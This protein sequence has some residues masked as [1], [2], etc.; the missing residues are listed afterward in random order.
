MKKFL[1][2]LIIIFTICS[3]SLIPERS[4]YEQMEDDRFGSMF[5]P[6]RDFRVVSGDFGHVHREQEEMLSRTPASAHQRQ[7]MQFQDS[8]KQELDG[9]RSKLSEEELHHFA[10]NEKYLANSSEKIYFLRL[11][12]MQERNSYLLSKGIKTRY[13]PIDALWSRSQPVAQDV[14]LGMSKQDV[15]SIWGQPARIDIAGDPQYQ[16]ERWAYETGHSYRYVYF[17]G[18]RVEGWSTPNAQS[19]YVSR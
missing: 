3:C 4:F 16:N 10:Q 19:Q 7:M 1:S 2:Q 17:E 14:S 15:E 6:G 12:N 18:G 8:F 11:S 5:A 9:L 13:S